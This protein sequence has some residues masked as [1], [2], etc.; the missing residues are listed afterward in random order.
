VPH[1]DRPPG[2]PDRTVESVLRRERYNRNTVPGVRPRT[3]KPMLGRFLCKYTLE[4]IG[5]KRSTMWY[6]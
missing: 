1:T 6:L 4:L 2:L 3:S 5:V